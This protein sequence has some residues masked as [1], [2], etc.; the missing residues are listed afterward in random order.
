MKPFQYILCAIMLFCCHFSFSQSV[1]SGNHPSNVKWKYIKNDKL[2]VIF[3]DSTEK[4]AKR[5]ADIIT[6]INKEK[7]F[8]VGD[9][10]LH[11]DL[12][13][14]TNNSIG[15][16]YVAK[17]PFRSEFYATGYQDS[18]TLSTL[19]WL[20]ALSIHEYRHVLQAANTRRGFSQLC[21]YIGGESAWA[22]AGVFAV[23]NWYSEGDAV[24]SETLLSESGRGRTPSFFELQRALFLNNR[25][26]NFMQMR[27]GSFKN[28]IPNHY[29]LG[30][31]LVNYGRNHYDDQVWART[32]ANA[33]SYKS[34]FYPF[35]G[36]MKKE[37]GFTTRK[38]YKK[39]YS[40]LKDKWIKELETI[41]ILPTKEVTV[42]PKSVVTNYLFPK[43]LDDGSVVCI[44]NSFDDISKL[45]QI[46]NGIE[47]ELT[48]I[49][50]STEDYLELTGDTVCWTEI[51][52]DGRRKEMIYSVIVSYNLKTG[53]KK[54]ITKKSKYFSPVFS[55]NG[56][57]ILTV[58]SDTKIRNT[59]KILDASSGKVLKTIPNPQNDFIS[60]PKWIENEN[61]IVYIAKRNSKLAFL[62]YDISNSSVVELSPWTSHT[63][64]PFSIKNN[65]IYFPASFSGINN[66]YC[67]KTDGSKEIKQITSVAVGVDMPQIANDG[68]TI[69]LSEETDMGRQL[70]QV[71]VLENL[72]ELNESPVEITEPV[73][74]ARF[75]IKTNVIE[76]PILSSIPEN[77]Y[78]IKD[79]KGFLRGMKLH[80]WGFTLNDNFSSV[81]IQFD[82]ILND[83]SFGLST[84]YNDNE[85]NWVI[86]ADAVYAKFFLPVITSYKHSKRQNTLVFDGNYAAKFN[87]DEVSA[88]IGF[89][90]PL[91]WTRSVY[92]T[93]LNLMP[94]FSNI[95]TS[96]YYNKDL[97]DL[98]GGLNFNSAHAI[99]QFSNIRNR[100][101]QNLNSK[102]SQQI[103]VDYNKSLTSSVL[104]EKLTA[105]VKLTAQGF[106][107]NH[108]LDF[109]FKYKKELSTNDYL[110][111][112]I[113]LHARG[114]Q[115]VN[116]D[117]ETV[118]SANYSFPLFY[119][120]FGFGGLL[121]L[122]RIHTNLFFD[123]GKIQ[124]KAYEFNQN[125]TGIE[126]IFNLTPF[127]LPAPF[128]IGLRQSFLLD[129]DPVNSKAKSYF[130][131]FYNISF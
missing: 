108:G 49:G 103:V 69:Y 37:T 112:D 3:P 62:K 131:V 15:N 52:N 95:K 123:S 66:V 81:G 114:Y 53:V 91:S 92:T 117:L 106:S 48:T 2:K 1:A 39:A 128:E 83:F 60:Y 21:Y 109:N 19:N 58:C 56:N 129:V 97:G 24:H 12:L 22:A 17:A 54:V 130:E 96:N 8:S 116:S 30:Y 119:P 10:R 26:Y 40:D 113:F 84:S 76:K 28:N 73:D 71:N 46:K 87:F 93:S 18:Q 16:G 79:Y 127:N 47:K 86:G 77:E 72:S 70:T 82:N 65:R 75:D 94:V 29:V 98:S 120:D 126:M 122:K 88:N 4:E 121:F 74:M 104:A 111:S 43:T 105:N 6:F 36:A 14:N 13:L 80:T 59:I 44:K 115:A 5:I 107:K 63:I 20:D 7:G 50:Y 125:S 61:A 64:G 85:K 23:P 124:G 32:L 34:V 35:S 9:K 118:Y 89:S 51:R 33:A 42:K 38:F 25:D 99:F 68:N 31:N 100:A 27:N 90:V 78:E 67:V 45:I 55:E 57:K 101:K 11:L 102:W 110:Y 41:K